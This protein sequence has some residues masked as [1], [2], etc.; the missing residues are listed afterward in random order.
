MKKTDIKLD[1]STPEK[2]K[3][4]YHVLRAY[5]QGF[6]IFQN[7]N[8]K[9]GITGEYNSIVFSLTYDKWI[10]RKCDANCDIPKLIQ[11]LEEEQNPLSCK[12][13][14]KVDNEREF[15]AMMIYYD[16]KG[17]KWRHGLKPLDYKFISKTQ[18]TDYFN[19]KKEISQWTQLNAESDG[20]KI[21]PFKDFVKI[22]GIDYMDKVEIN[23]GNLYVTVNEKTAYIGSLELTHSEIAQI[24]KA[25]QQF[26]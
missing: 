6:F 15:N 3:K 17:L 26:K 4:V 19:G 25:C 10:F 13:A 9:K 7:V 24:H 18:L 14:I 21:I 23:M 5:N 22:A 1:I 16:S 12:V 8:L 11:I 2:A 20:Y